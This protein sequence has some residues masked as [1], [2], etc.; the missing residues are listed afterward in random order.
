MSTMKRSLVSVP[1]GQ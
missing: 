1:L